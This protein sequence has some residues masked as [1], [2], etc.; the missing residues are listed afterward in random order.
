MDNGWRRIGLNG[1]KGEWLA[2]AIRML[3]LSSGHVWL[4]KNFFLRIDSG[5]GQ[6]LKAR[7]NRKRY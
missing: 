6:V 1:S 3:D 5:N 4:F 7:E 2:S